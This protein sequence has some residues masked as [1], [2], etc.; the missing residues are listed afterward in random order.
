MLVGVV[1]TGSLLVGYWSTV[2]CTE[3]EL[4]THKVQY[5]TITKYWYGYGVG[6]SVPVLT[7]LLTPTPYSYC[8][9]AYE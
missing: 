3:Y 7:V 4:R 9:P 6:C 1:C 2:L 8:T 5:H